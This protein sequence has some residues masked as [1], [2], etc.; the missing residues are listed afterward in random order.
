MTNVRPVIKS[1]CKQ[2]NI[3]T[4]RLISNETGVK[5][6]ACNNAALPSCTHDD[7]DP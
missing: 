1:I 3:K 5:L 2:Q 4:F 6:P 7:N